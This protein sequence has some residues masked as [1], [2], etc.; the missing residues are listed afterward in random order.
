MARSGV[1]SAHAIGVESAYGTPVTTT[2]AIP[3]IS[4]DIQTTVQQ[5]SPDVLW[6]GQIVKPDENI[7]AG[8]I[9]HLGPIVYPLWDVGLEEIMRIAWGGYSFLTDTHTFSPD[10][11]DESHTHAF[12]FGGD[13]GVP[14]K[15][16][17][18]G[19]CTGWTL[20]MQAGE[21]ATFT[22][23]MAYQGLQVADA[24]AVAGSLPGALLPLN[25][26]DLTVFTVAGQS[27]DCVRGF[28]I[29]ADNGY[30]IERLCLGHTEIKDPRVLAGERKYTGTFTLDFEDLATATPTVIDDF[31][32]GNSALATAI[33]IVN[34]TSTFSITGQ[35]RVEGSVPNIAGMGIASLPVPVT[36]AADVGD[37]AAA[38][39]MTVNN[40]TATLN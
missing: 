21:H 27:F 17:E 35:V 36:W 33:T 3:F 4:E 15:I 11:A 1:G 29:T 5:I 19:V 39:K 25:W 37:D 20:S 18:G 38:L 23:T 9:T 34:G 24:S 2:A 22:P 31:L 26:T 32:S 8:A 28:E 12:G 6:P 10:I 40:G 13:T 14:R 16:Y 7:R 30:D